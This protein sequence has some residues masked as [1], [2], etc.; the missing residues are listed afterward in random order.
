M[1]QW[2]TRVVSPSGLLRITPYYPTLPD[3][4]D[5]LRITADNF[6]LLRFTRVPGSPVR[7]IKWS[8]GL[9]ELFPPRDYCEL[10]HITPNYRITPIYFVLLR[11]TLDYSGFLGL[12]RITSSNDQVV[13]R[14]TRVVSP[15]GLLRITPYYPELPDYSDLLRITADNFRLLRFPW[16]TPDHQF[17]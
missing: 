10:R 13:Q 7:I 14:I 9:L 16:I 12:P 4:H 8:S 5:L 17:E 6:G 3:Y 11:I 1:V 15:S 2:I